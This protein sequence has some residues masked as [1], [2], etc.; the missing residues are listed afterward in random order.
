[1]C[2]DT[3]RMFAQ[4]FMAAKKTNAQNGDTINPFNMTKDGSGICPTITTRP[5]GFKTAILVIEKAGDT[6]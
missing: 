6:K 3:Y 4:A 1:M 5:E 2:A